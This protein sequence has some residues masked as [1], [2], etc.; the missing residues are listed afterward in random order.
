MATHM[1]EIFARRRFFPVNFCWARAQ[2]T[3]SAYDAYIDAV[4]AKEVHFGV[5]LP[6]GRAILD[7]LLIF[8]TTKDNVYA[9]ISVQQKRIITH[10]GSKCLSWQD[11]QFAIRK[12]RVLGL[13]LANTDG[14]FKTWVYWFSR[15]RPSNS[16]HY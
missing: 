9:R 16:G 12:S 6:H 13:G 7:K 8:K 1:G 15:S 14:F 11:T 10:D 5:S 3:P 2:P 4:S